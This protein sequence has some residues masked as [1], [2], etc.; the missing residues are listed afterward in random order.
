MIDSCYKRLSNGVL[1]VAVAVSESFDMRSGHRSHAA[2]R[3]S[4]DNALTSIA[5]QMLVDLKLN[6]HFSNRG[7]PMRGTFVLSS[8]SALRTKIVQDW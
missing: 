4:H 3:R 6:W 7:E 1:L 2:R 5:P 8:R